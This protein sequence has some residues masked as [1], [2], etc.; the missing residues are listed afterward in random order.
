MYSICLPLSLS[1]SDTSDW[2]VKAMATLDTWWI[3]DQAQSYT[4]VK[5]VGG[6][7]KSQLYPWKAIHLVMMDKNTH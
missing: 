2:D 6:S 1:H 4:D 5:S 7:E 3:E